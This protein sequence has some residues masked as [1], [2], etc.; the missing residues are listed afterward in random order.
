MQTDEQS[1]SESML[2]HEEEI[3]VA[4]T[5]SIVVGSFLFCWFPI[6]INL[7]GIS[8][9]R[10][11]NFFYDSIGRN[12]NLCTICCTHLNSAIDPIIYAFRMKEVR[13]AVKNLI[14]K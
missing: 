6:T 7:L 11:R 4:K 3:K 12:F 2:N 13:K 8:I 14:R 9:S 5:I 10:D 1:N